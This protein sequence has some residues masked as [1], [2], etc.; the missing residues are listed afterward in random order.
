VGAVSGLTLTGCTRGIEGTVAASHN[1]NS[2]VTHLLTA[3]S[4]Q[5]LGGNTYPEIYQVKFGGTQIS[6]LTLDT[7]PPNGSSILMYCDAY[8]TAHVTAISSTNTTW[9]KLTDV[10]AGA[11]YS[12]WIGLVSGGAGGTAI[13]FT[14]VNSYL[15]VFAINIADT[16]TGTLG[17][18]VFGAQ[19]TTITTPAA[20]AEGNL[21]AVFGGLDNTTL[22]NDISVLIP[23]LGFPTGT[24][25]GV[26]G[27]SLGNKVTAQFTPNAGRLVIAEIT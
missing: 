27:Y 13:T 20:P 1:D 10:S 5:T 24:V 6:S 16:L 26:V 15:S 7:A 4:I 19:S 22:T 17:T 23:T 25:S 18:S 21:V 14:H 11:Y 3:G 12:L 2:I 8:N 9:T